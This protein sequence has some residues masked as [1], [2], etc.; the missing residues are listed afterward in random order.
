[1]L[2]WAE[3]FEPPTDFSQNGMDANSQGRFPPQ[4]EPVRIDRFIEKRF[5]VSPAYGDLPDGVLGMAKF[6]DVGVAELIVAKFLEDEPFERRR[7]TTLAHEAGHGL[8][9]AYLFVLDHNEEPL[10]C[11][12]SELKK[13]KFMCRENCGQWWEFQANKAM[14][15]LLMPRILEAARS[16]AF[17]SCTLTGFGASL[18]H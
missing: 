14:A 18:Y 13:P 8:L 10:F 2:V 11:D 9:H 17:R 6:T 5:M 4:P 16:I 1:M 7:R 12:N 3:G 15:A